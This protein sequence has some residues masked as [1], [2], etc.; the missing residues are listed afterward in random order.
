LV[1]VTLYTRNECGLCE[2]V[3]DILRGLQF[4]FPHHLKRVDIDSDESLLSIYS[5]RIPVLRAGDRQIEAPITPDDILSLLEA[6]G[7]DITK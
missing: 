2:D 3:E 5:D 7:E 4:T 1:T 6:V